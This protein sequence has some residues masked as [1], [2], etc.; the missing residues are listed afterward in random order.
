[1]T[2]QFWFLIIVF[3]FGMLVALGCR[4]WFLFG[5]WASLGVPRGAFWA[6]LGGFFCVSEAPLGSREGPLGSLWGLGGVGV[7]LCRAWAV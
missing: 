6:A 4:F 1:M 7:G 5:L 3:F 2:F